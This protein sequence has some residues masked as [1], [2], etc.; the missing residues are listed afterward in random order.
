[1]YQDRQKTL[2]E[3]AGDLNMRQQ[4][5]EEVSIA[6]NSIKSLEESEGWKE[7]VALIKTRIESLRAQIIGGTVEDTG[8]ARG[9][10][11]A[12]EWLAQS[13]QTA[14]VFLVGV[15]QA[16]EALDADKEDFIQGA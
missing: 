10:L 2:E 16:Q 4:R 3:H 7:L 13:P 8:F 14:D 12:L 1:M 9:E 6:W 11:K 5:I 15:K